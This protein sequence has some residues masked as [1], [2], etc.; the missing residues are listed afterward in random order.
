MVIRCRSRL[1]RLRHK[2]DS[3]FA[4]YTPAQRQL[5]VVGRVSTRLYSGVVIS[6]TDIEI[7]CQ[8]PREDQM[9]LVVVGTVYLLCDYCK[10]SAGNMPSGTLTYQVSREPASAAQASLRR[11]FLSA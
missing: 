4:D 10:S 11:L 9:R 5:P 8:A 1:A 2:S 7:M 3:G 6:S